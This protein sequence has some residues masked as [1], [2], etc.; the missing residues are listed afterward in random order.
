MKILIVMDPG[1]M[2][3][4]KGYG[5]IERMIEMLAKK[6]L[7]L[8]HE[9]HLLVTTGS[10][11]KGCTVHDFGR[12]GFPPDK[13]DAR[14]AIPAAWQFLW[15]HRNQFD[16]VHNFGRLIYLLPIL[17]HPIKKIMSY[18]R[19][20]TRRNV[21]LMAGLPN[22]NMFF[23]GCSK[24]LVNRVKLN[25]KWQAI[26]NGCDFA[27]YHLREQLTTDAPLVF[28]GRI[29]KIKGC[30]TAIR[31]AK[32]TGN[33][34]IIAGNI[35]TL[36]EEKAYYETAIAPNIDGQQIRYIGQVNDV[37]KNELLGSAKALLFPIEWAEPFGIVMV[38][39]MA[40][41][42]P[43]IAFNRGS[44]NE[45]I[46]EGVTGFKIDTENEMMEAVKIVNSLS[47]ARCRQR[48]AERF[49][50]VVIAKQYLD[51]VSSE[52]KPLEQCVTVINN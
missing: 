51:F 5:G 38:E 10:T 18:Q 15:K 4:V 42:T 13:W 39:A 32:A 41:G 17:N 7:V 30:H 46:D 37:Q 19:E 26:Y 31:V 9:V 44:V 34:L 36:P 29:E 1:I 20:I 16:L 22:K 11:V 6:Y 21:Q 40:C 45:V 28:L 3:P 27:T 14:K 2:I 33:N 47:R 48:A 50:A 35:S 43:V 12:E 25:G 23:T 49:D 52:T 24:D 8:G